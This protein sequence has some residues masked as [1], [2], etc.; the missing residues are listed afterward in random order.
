MVI[1]EARIP[2][3]IHI[4]Y[5]TDSSIRNFFKIQDTIW[6]GYFNKKLNLNYI[7]KLKIQ[8]ID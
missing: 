8:T 5:G 1:N 2:D 6:P 3:T 7:L 4:R